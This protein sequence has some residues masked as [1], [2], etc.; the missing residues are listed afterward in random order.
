MK[1]ANQTFAEKLYL[2][3]ESDPR[4]KKNK[5]VVSQIAASDFTRIDLKKPRRRLS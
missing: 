4:V 5:Y 3:L 2:Q 1:Q